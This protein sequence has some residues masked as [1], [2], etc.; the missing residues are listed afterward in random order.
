MP[1]AAAASIAR[2]ST[3]LGANAESNS[4]WLSPGTWSPLISPSTT[5]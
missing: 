5:R 2:A 4:K 1:A 3:R